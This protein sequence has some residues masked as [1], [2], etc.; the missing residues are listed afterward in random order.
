MTILLFILG[1]VLFVIGL[2]V[3]INGD[4][5]SVIIGAIIAIIG[6]CFV[7]YTSAMAAEDSKDACEGIGGKYVVVDREYNISLKQVVNV[8]G[9]VK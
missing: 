2:V 6:L 8:Y 1:V 7:I 5:P 9:C 3:A 4:A